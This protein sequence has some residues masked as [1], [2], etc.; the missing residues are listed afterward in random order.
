MHSCRRPISGL[1][2]ALEPGRFTLEIEDNGRGLGD[3][4]TA[5]GRN[6]LR[7]MR[8]RLEDVGG[9]FDI[10]PGAEGG[11]RVSLTAPLGKVTGGEG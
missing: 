5:K 8:K 7:N 1:T 6:G 10:G 11:T 4:A 2:P 9:E 3:G